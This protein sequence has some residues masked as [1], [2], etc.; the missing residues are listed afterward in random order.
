[1]TV[2]IYLLAGLLILWASV[3]VIL[4]VYFYRIAM[5]RF[6]RS[7]AEKKKG[8]PLVPVSGGGEQYP[9][10]WNESR[11]WY[12][13]QKKQPL[14]ITSPDGLTL[15]GALLTDGDNEKLALVIHGWTGSKEEMGG[16]ARLYRKMGFAVLTPDLRA[17]GESDGKLIGFGYKDRLDMLRWIDLAISLGARQILVTGHSMGG[18]TTMM[19][20]GEKLPA[21]VKCFVEDCGFSSAYDQFYDTLGKILPKPLRPFRRPVLWLA[22]E[23]NR[24]KQG[25][26]MKQASSIKQLEK[27]S[28]P[29]LFIH[30]D[31]DEFVPYSMLDKVFA[32]CASPKE[33]L[34]VH[35]AGHCKSLPRDPAL[36]EQAVRAFALKYME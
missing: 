31:K 24:R 35:G 11:E 1:M 13:A 22:G 20:A 12:N 3:V 4:S 28:K 2:V 7:A 15:R 23:I 34:T 5:T 9:T 14:S 21:Q 32:A 30:G 33:K 6:D 16:V 19:T 26:T 36:Y 10:Y 17:H 18:A 27:A 8:K 29:V 25:F